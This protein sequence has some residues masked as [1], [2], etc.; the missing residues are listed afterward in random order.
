MGSKQMARGL[1]MNPTRQETTTLSHLESQV[2]AALS[3]SSAEE[4]HFWLM[5][6]VRYIV[7]AGNESRLRE[8]CEEL[9]SSETKSSQTGTKILCYEK[10][11]PLKDMLPIIASNLRFQ[12]FY[13]EF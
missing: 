7:Q 9:L 2:S 1:R 5:T 3:M 12:R 4:Y 8:L 6:Y 10:R 13:S 11:D